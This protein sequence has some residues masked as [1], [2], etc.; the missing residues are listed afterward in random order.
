MLA[1]TGILIF[2]TKFAQKGFF[3]SRP[4]NVNNLI[5]FRIFELVQKPHFHLN[6][7]ILFF[8]LNFPKTGSSTLSQKK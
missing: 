2:W 8:G 4:G 5:E 6:K 7:Q 3:W 1:L